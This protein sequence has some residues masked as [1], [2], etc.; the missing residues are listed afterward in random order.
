[1]CRTPVTFGGGRTMLYG[2]RSLLG[3]AVKYP[4]DTQRS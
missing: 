3:S 1:M 2:S 4:S